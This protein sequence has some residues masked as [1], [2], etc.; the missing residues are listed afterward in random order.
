MKDKFVTFIMTII[1]IMIFSALALLGMI[2]FNEFQE[3]QT[4][5]EPQVVEA[6]ENEKIEE[7]YM[8][9]N[10]KNTNSTENTISDVTTSVSSIEKE[11]AEKEIKVPQIVDNPLDQ[12]KPEKADQNKN[13]NYTNVSIDGYF[14]NQLE[15]YSKVIYRAFESNKEEMKT[16]NYQI[17][18]GDAFSGLLKQSDG[19]N[20]L[21]TYYQSAIEA[22]IYDNPEVFYLNPNKMY[23]NIETTTR[24]NNVSYNAFINS[25]G[26]GSYLTDEFSS[27]QQINQ[28]INILRQTRQN[29]IQNKTGNTYKDIKMVHDYI[30]N[31]T[32]YDTTVS[33]ENI[34]NIYGTLVN[35][36]SVCEGY[37]KTFKYVMDELG[38]QCI[39]VIGKATNSEGSTENHAWNYVKID[40]S[41]YGIDTTWDDPIST[42][43]W[44][45]ENSKYKYFLKGL[46][47]MSED[48]TPSGQFS[49]GGKIFNYPNI[50]NESYRE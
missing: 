16:G 32:E 12:I 30:I 38:I 43:G 34:Y 28:A 40:G 1:I 3:I 10:K 19:Q 33:K 48:H 22:Y 7:N 24:G 23:L 17:E 36:Q 25:G 37:A 39:L 45:S 31:N 15:D 2:F 13:N 49:E 5:V 20:L 50:S 35:K 18:F 21:N 11:K 9:S 27:K 46:N 47:E 26:Y 41:W 14:Y 8:Q 4:V 6:E 42:S 44:V 29:I